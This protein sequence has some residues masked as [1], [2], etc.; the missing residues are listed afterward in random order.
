MVDDGTGNGVQIPSIMIGKTDGEKLITKYSELASQ[1]TIIQLIL[2]FEINKPDDRVEY[3]IWFSSS[4]DRGL[5]FISDFRSYHEKLG[6]KVLMTPRYFSWPCVNCDTSITDEDC[7]CEGKYCA[8][9]ETNLRVNGK[10][11]IHENLRQKCIYTNS[12]KKNQS[13]KAWWDY[14]ALAHAKCYKDISEDC[15]KVVHAELKLDYDETE[16]CVNASFDNADH[17]LGDNAILN[18]EAQTWNTHGSHFIPAVIINSVAYRGTLDPENVFSAI[19]N[20]F[21]D[22]QDE[23]KAY[24]DSIDEGSNDK[25]TFNW[26]I[27]VIIFLILLNI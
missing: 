21:K 10:D 16:K 1:K 7:F 20:S 18:D 8:M 2:S 11:I 15:S 24:V 23:C 25:V 4:N 19:C 27:V 9:D 13:D 5:D 6:K 26:F 14:L 22:V 17:G 12:M 3:D